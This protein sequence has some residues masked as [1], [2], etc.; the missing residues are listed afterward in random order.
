MVT[1]AGSCA[2]QLRHR[3]RAIVGDDRL[4]LART[5]ISS[6][7]AAPGRP[8]RSAAAAASRSLDCPR[9]QR[10]DRPW[11][12]G[13]SRDLASR[14]PSAATWRASATANP[15]RRALARCAV[16]EDA[17][18]DACDVLVAFV[19]RRCPCR[20]CLVVSNGLNR[21]SR[22][23]SCVMP[24]PVVPDLDDREV[25]IAPDTPAAPGPPAASRRGRSARDGRARARAD[26][27]GPGRTPAASRRGRLRARVPPST[28]ATRRAIAV[29]RRCCRGFSTGVSPARSW[30]M[31]IAHATDDVSDRPS[32]S[33]W[34]S[35]LSLCR[36]AFLSS[37][38]SCATRFFRSWTT[39]AD[40]RLNA[41]NLRASSSASVARDLRE[42]A[43]R[44]AAGGLEQVAHLPVDVDR[45][46]GVG[47]HDEADQLVRREQRHDQPGIGQRLQP[48]G[49]HEVREYR[50]GSARYSR[51]ST[52]Q[53]VAREEPRERA[54][55]R[56]GFASPRGM[57]HR[58]TWRKR[59]PSHRS[60]SAP[61]GL[62]TRSAS[63]R[64]TVR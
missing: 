50:S 41:S 34:N 8:R 20:S 31:Q 7:S 40:I 46:R 32:M 57:F 4:V 45:A 44:L 60:Q 62:S 24:T 26:P 15:Y 1:T 19:A 49:Q 37:S 21:R 56:L 25:S 22:T 47:Q 51:S 14:T 23:N 54:V 16:D 11:A 13:G 63:A 42:I 35:G 59:R 5:P 53:P 61:P 9:A 17:A 55:E 12:A 39:K 52:T 10:S 36:S 38:C 29:E 6:A 33:R 30:S 58:A 28:A 27:R 2:P 43:R 64:T 48:G 3:A 18:A